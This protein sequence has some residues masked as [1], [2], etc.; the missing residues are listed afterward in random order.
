MKMRIMLG[1]LG[2]VLFPVIFL[3]LAALQ[4]MGG[5]SLMYLGV[6]GSPLGFLV[7]ISYADR[8][9]RF[10]WKAIL[11]RTFAGFVIMFAFVSVIVQ[12]RISPFFVSNGWILIVL[13]GPLLSAAA[14]EFILRNRDR[15]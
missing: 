9:R 5:H 13:V 15:T 3:P 12:I 8:L 4:T 7:G 11:V 14:T 10:F 2:A 6:F 1:Y